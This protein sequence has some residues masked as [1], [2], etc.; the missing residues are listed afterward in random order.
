MGYKI[1][2]V[3]LCGAGKSTFIAALEDRL[4]SDEV[5][6][7]DHP[8]IP[9]LLF[10]AIYILK[11]L[12]FGFATEPIVFSKFLSKRSNWWLVKKVAYRQAGMRLRGNKNYILVDCGTLQPF[13]SFEIEEKVTNSNVPIEPLLCGCKLPDII[14]FFH[15]SPFLAKNRYEIRGKRGQGRVARKN[16][17]QY[18]ERAEEVRKNLFEYCKRMEIKT[19]ELDTT[20]DFTDQYITSTLIEIKKNLS[21]IEEKKHD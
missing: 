3:G 4:I 17:D 13:L 14:L 6:E 9:N 2:L 16:C 8:V 18:F 1:E 20:Q 12:L 19:I 5:I 7:L 21:N 15:V 10:F 11:I